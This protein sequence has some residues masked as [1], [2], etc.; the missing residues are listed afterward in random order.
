VLLGDPDSRAHLARQ[1]DL[2]RSVGEFLTSLD[3]IKISIFELDTDRSL[4]RFLVHMS[5]PEW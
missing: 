3:L 2:R 4:V 1:K 5:T